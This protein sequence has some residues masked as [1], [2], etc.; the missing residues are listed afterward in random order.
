[1][2]LIDADALKTKA[3]KMSTVSSP[4]VYMKAVGTREI[5]NAPHHRR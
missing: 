2:I 4:H 5:D 1:M 3:I